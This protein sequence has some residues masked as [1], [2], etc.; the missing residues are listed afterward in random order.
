MKLSLP[1][2]AAAFALIAGTNGFAATNSG[3]SGASVADLT[4]DA[5]A[6]RMDPNTVNYE[7]YET[8]STTRSYSSSGNNTGATNVRYVTTSQPSSRGQLYRTYTG[9]G[10]TSSRTTTT[11]RGQTVRT[12]MK[13]KY[14]LAH[15]FFQPTEGKFGSITDLSYNDASYK[16]R[17]TPDPDVLASIED[18]GKWY[19]NQYSVKED[20]SF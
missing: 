1:I 12:S 14:Y 9:G 13:R 2:Y 6:V 10:N 19:M 3:M 16:M 18:S 17:F 15:P 11:N 8:R 20:F 7:K 5:P 4:T